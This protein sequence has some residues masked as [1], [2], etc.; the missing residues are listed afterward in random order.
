MNLPTFENELLLLISFPTKLIQAC[1]HLQL[2]Y[3]QKIK[4]L[5]MLILNQMIDDLKLGIS[6]AC[7]LKWLSSFSL[8]LQ[9]RSN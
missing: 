4:E 9:Y 6:L 3:V 5:D 1:L 7:T 8:S 2:T